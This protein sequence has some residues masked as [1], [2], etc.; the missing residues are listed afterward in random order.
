MDGQ[1]SV[2]AESPHGVEGVGQGE[3]LRITFCPLIDRPAV[4]RWTKQLRA[5]GQRVSQA[6]SLRSASHAVYPRVISVSTP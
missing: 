3:N 6:A 1:R 5:L 2:D 4:S